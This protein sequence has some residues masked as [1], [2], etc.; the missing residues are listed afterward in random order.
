LPG[1]EAIKIIP[2]LLVASGAESKSAD[3]AGLH[4]VVVFLVSLDVL[5]VLDTAVFG[6]V[7]LQAS[8]D[9]ARTESLRYAEPVREGVDPK[10]TQK[11]HFDNHTRRELFKRHHVVGATSA[12]FG[13]AN[14]PFDIRD[15]L[16]FTADI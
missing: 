8:D 1:H 4:G 3:S 6:I 16:V 2:A 9:G 12:F 13:G 7:D 10:N 15:V 11:D 14:A 5:S